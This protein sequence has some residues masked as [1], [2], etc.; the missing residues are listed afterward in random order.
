MFVVPLYTIRCQSGPL[1][2]FALCDFA[3]EGDA[4]PFRNAMRHK[5]SIN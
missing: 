2:Q 3:D 5:Y 4:V 1:A